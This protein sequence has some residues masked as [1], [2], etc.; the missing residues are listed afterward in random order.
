MIITTTTVIVYCGRAGG[1]FHS[2]IYNYQQHGNRQI[3]ES[4]TSGETNNRQRDKSKPVIIASWGSVDCGLLRK[5]NR[6]RER[7]NRSLFP[8]SPLFFRGYNKFMTM[9]RYQASSRTPHRSI[10]CPWQWVLKSAISEIIISLWQRQS[11]H[12]IG[13]IT[14]TNSA[15][16]CMVMTVRL[17]ITQRQW[18][19]TN[20]RN[21]FE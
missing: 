5:E 6:G 13:G 12:S 10:N 19:K 2:T 8:F 3:Y 4:L 17:T 9:I 20:R 14:T 11:Q 16:G 18:C 1:H 21:G 15:D 7:G